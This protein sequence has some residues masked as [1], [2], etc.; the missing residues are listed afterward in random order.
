[1][2][3]NPDSKAL[4]RVFSGST[5]RRSLIM[6]IVVGT[7]LNLI[8]QGH[9]LVDPGAIDVWRALLTYLVPFGVASYG[10]YTAYST[11]QE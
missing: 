1:M 10:A 6:A 2:R 3:L 5:L 4:Q 8:N 7:L 9:H 11:L